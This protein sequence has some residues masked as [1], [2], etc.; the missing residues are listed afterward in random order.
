MAVKNDLQQLI[1]QLPENATWDDVLVY[2]IRER[3]LTSILSGEEIALDQ[4]SEGDVQAV[5]NRI[6]SVKDAPADLINTETPQADRFTTWAIGAGIVSFLPIPVLSWALMAVAAGAGVLG[7]FKG[8]SKAFVGI[9]L[10]LV[11]FMLSAL[12]EPV[13]HYLE[14]LAGR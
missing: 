8:E 6:Y 11:S 1:N 5:L 4:M 2:A 10:A 12:S 3:K 9:A 14:V 13:W 7:I